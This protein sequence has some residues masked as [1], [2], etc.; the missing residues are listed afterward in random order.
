MWDTTV[1]HNKKQNFKEL[2]KNNHV[3]A[4]AG[5]SDAEFTHTEMISEVCF[6]V[7]TIFPYIGIPNYK[8]KTDMSW[9]YLYNGDPYIC[10]TAS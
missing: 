5:S 9:S 8:N 1:L 6:N 7:N 2:M 4:W 10:K 3:F